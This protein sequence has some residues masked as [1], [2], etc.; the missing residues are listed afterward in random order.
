MHFHPIP[1]SCQFRQ[2]HFSQDLPSCNIEVE[3][4]FAASA[5]NSNH[6][7][8]SLEIKSATLSEILIKGIQLLAVEYHWV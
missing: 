5:K 7:V 2:L 1:Q 4:N 6:C 8:N 3:E